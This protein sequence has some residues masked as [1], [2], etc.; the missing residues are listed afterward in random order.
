[1]GEKKIRQVMSV[2]EIAERRM[3][4]ATIVLDGSPAP[5]ALGAILR[6]NGALNADRVALSFEGVDTTYAE[7]LRA[8]IRVA[9]AL[10]AEGLA[11]GER[12]AILAKNGINFFEVLFGAA[13]LGVVVVPINWRLT[14]LE[15]GFLIGDSGARLLFAG[16]EHTGLAD[17]V[18]SKAEFAIRMIEFDGD[19]ARS[20]ARWRDMSDDK[21]CHDSI[22]ADMVAL[23]L[24]TSGTTGKPKGALL[25]HHSLNSV[26]VSQPQAGWN[27]WNAA[28]SCLVSMPLF[29]IGGIGTALASIYH[30]ARTV[31]ARDF[32]PEALFD[33]I[34]RDRITRLFLAPTAMHILLDHP[35]VR[36]TDF[37]RLRYIL[38]GSSPISAAL[39]R[40]A[41]AVF[42]CGFVQLYGMTE[43]S[44]AV[45]ALSPEDHDP[46]RNPR[47]R[48]AGKALHGVEIV[49]LDEACNRLA[50]GK[51]GE[52]SIRSQ[53]NMLG[54][55]GMPEATAACL[56][57]DGFFR[58]GD[59]G[60]L[61]E[62]GYLFICDR[63]KDMII[64]GGENVYSAEVEAVLCEYPCVVEAAVIGVPDARWGEAVEAVIVSATGSATNAE[65]LRSWA[66]SKL[67]GYKVPKSFHFVTSLPKNSSG[68][69]LHRQLREYYASND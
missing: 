2:G 28:D 51:V 30:G 19:S 47:A 16:Q 3:M 4:D 65:D 33:Y 50:S 8:S 7:L 41:V 5:P 37:T 61:D 62:D 67:A 31:I 6:I 20:Y 10:R 14:A 9:N 52:V 54:Y 35:R 1:M 18:A 59:V 57:P 55:W 21:D 36:S 64:T 68:K 26:R 12:V 69:V 43:T 11:R 60:Y 29:H 24:Y 25:T 49:I 66:R 63:L 45:V 15:I 46:E 27:H 56:Q 22:T 58:S 23:Q 40:Q 34:E 17:E 13:M 48:S 38:Y 44:G 39:L 32:T 53:A 42:G